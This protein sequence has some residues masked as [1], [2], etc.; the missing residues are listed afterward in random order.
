M[1]INELLRLHRE[2]IGFT[3]EQLAET[4][5]VTRQAVS[6]WER[7]ESLPDLENIIILSD[8]YDISIDELLRGAKFLVKP[9][10]IGEHSFRRN[11]LIGIIISLSFS[12]IVSGGNNLVV[13]S[14]VLIFLV[15]I[16]VTS[17]KEGKII[18]TKQGIKVVDYK[19][20]IQKIRSVFSKD[21]NVLNY[22]FNEINSFS[23]NYVKRLRM[24]PFD[25]HPDIF[26]VVF[27]TSDGKVHTQTST[28]QVTKSLPIICDYLMKK[29]VTVYDDNEI[30]EIIIKGENIYEVLHR[31]N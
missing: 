29:G 15:L 21:R 6:K 3:Q 26:Q 20:T 24:S 11:L 19:N 18:I 22:S 28:P 17:I 30:I 27:R 25:F 12:F 16:T 2:K 13:F 7:G 4:I 9:F 8:L 14:F 10:Q 5:Y 1:K 23:I 31:D